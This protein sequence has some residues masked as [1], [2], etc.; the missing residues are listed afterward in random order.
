MPSSE[1]GK[2]GTISRIDYVKS[3]T[4]D[5]VF[6][7]FLK[8]GDTFTLNKMGDPPPLSFDEEIQTGKNRQKKKTVRSRGTVKCQSA[9]TY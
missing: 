3:G 8:E 7:N 9:K 5:F 2:T 1:D 6:Q 4:K